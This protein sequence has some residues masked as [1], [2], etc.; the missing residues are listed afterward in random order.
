MDNL[1][2]VL[3]AIAVASVLIIV[4]LIINMIMQED[5]EHTAHLSSVGELESLGYDAF[6]YDIEL[7]LCSKRAQ[8]VLMDLHMDSPR[9]LALLTSDKLLSIK[10]CG[11]STVEEIKV[12]ASGFDIFIV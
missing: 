1:G 3:I 6:A 12:L 2:I 5:Q 9:K 10:G 11:P 8:R 7:A 4:A